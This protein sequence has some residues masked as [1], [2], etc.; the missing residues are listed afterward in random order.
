MGLADWLLAPRPGR[1]AFTLDV[2]MTKKSEIAFRVRPYLE[3]GEEVDE[4]FMAQARTPYLFLLVPLFGYT[5]GVV[6]YLLLPEV[7][8]QLFYWLAYFLFKMFGY[9]ILLLVPLLLCG[10]VAAYILLWRTLTYH[11]IGPRIVVVTSHNVIV[12]RAQGRWPAFPTDTRPLARLPVQ[13]RFGKRLLWHWRAVEGERLW[14]AGRPHQDVAQVG[15]RASARY[16]LSRVTHC[17]LAS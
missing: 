8:N 12:L 11:V 6:V 4:V 14:I 9:G 5:I 3:P 17:F 15:P 1:I 13:T 10:F 7:G 16:C 2:E